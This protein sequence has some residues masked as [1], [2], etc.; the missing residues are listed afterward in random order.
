MLD[1]ETV[2]KS[3]PKIWTSC[4]QFLVDTCISKKYAFSFSKIIFGRST[5]FS[6][7]HNQTPLL[8]I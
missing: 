3:K 1:S 4:L 6:L 7:G 2:R 5:N 8:S